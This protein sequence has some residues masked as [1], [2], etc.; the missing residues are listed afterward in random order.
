MLFKRTVFLEVPV[1][2]EV[3]PV[4]VPVEPEILPEQYARETISAWL[5][6]KFTGTGL[7]P[8]E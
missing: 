2:F 6:R 1:S 8:G 5:Q 4:V 3:Q 7:S